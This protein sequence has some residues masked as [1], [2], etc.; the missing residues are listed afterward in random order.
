[1]G[2][3][4]QVEAP[5]SEAPEASPPAPEPSAS[6]Q[7]SDGRESLKSSGAKA[8]TDDKFRT[9][10]SSKLTLGSVGRM[11]IPGLILTVKS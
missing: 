5:G 3:S 2:L 8:I 6:R 4:L 10:F 7:V 9:M 1:M 11:F